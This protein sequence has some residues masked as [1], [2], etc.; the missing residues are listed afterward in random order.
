MSIAFNNDHVLKEIL[1]HLH[2]VDCE[3]RRV[4]ILDL[5]GIV[6]DEKRSLIAHQLIKLRHRSCCV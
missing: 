1:E 4:A 5:A 6:G 2:A 3:V